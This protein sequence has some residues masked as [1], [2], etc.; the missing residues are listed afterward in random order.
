MTGTV[1]AERTAP[2]DPA[3]A[4]ASAQLA[5]T[6]RGA[7]VVKGFFDPATS[8]IS[9]VVH[10]PLTMRGAV[11]DSVLDY[12]AASG[13]TSTRS[14]EAI[15]NHVRA[16]GISIDW[17]LETHA[18]ADHLSAAPWLQKRLGGA[19]AIGEHIRDV[20]AVFGD[21]FNA[22]ADFRRDGS[23]FDRLWSDGDRFA[24]GD[25]PVTVLHAP[26]HTPACVAYAIGD[27]VFVGDTMFMPDYGSARA[28]F[29][30]GDAARLFRSLR[31]ILE[32]PGE[33]PL[34]LCHDYLTPGRQE[35]RWE[36]TVAEQRGANVHARD[37]ISEDE[38]VARRRARDAE[39]A[40]PALLLPA[41]QVNMRAGRLPPAENNGVA[42]LKIPIDRL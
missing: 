17:L 5:S 21:I 42:Y 1:G 3:L 8:T 41:V 22:G 12:D 9:Y 2:G 28:D 37:G 19:I 15:A 13:R 34:F 11:I 4:A 40:M 39:L 38:F 36:T 24:I 30:G 35:H 14:A 33:T 27:L 16:E 29:P 18:H 23:D 26:G 7:A 32:L 31:R 10:D 25:L 6:A 20:Q